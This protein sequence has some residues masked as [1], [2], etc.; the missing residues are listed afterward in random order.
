MLNERYIDQ[1]LSTENRVLR[2][3][4]ITQTYYDLSQEMTGLLGAENVN[5]CTFATHASKTAGYSI[6]H[7]IFP[8]NLETVLRRFERYEAAL[9]LLSGHLSRPS[10]GKTV[11]S[12]DFLSYIL[13]QVSEFVSQGNFL[14]F[15]DLAH[16]FVRFIW[17][18][19]DD[20]RP[21][22]AKFEQF[23]AGFR[24]GL[25]QHNGEDLL[26]DSFTAYY[27]AKFERDRKAKAEKILLANLLIGVYEQ[28][29]LQQAIEGALDAPVER[30]V[31]RKL[32]RLGNSCA[33]LKLADQVLFRHMVR[34][35]KRLF[36]EQATQALMVM[37]LPSGVKRLG[38]D[39][40]A[41]NSQ[42]FP[43]DLL[44]VRDPELVMVLQAWD[45]SWNSLRGSAARNW[46]S[47]AD[48][49]N[50]VVDYFRST[51]QNPMMYMAPFLP[52]QLDEIRR[53]VVPAGGL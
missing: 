46:A 37:R 20:K 30:L 52:K 43:A 17:A 48:R 28:T 9:G 14:V 5:W 2:N 31:A 40:T 19:Q 16:P 15:A 50:Y 26:I 44:E 1:T 41:G 6:R 3:L 47:L 10:A 18:F 51:Q 39:V 33:I 11:H 21:S 38:K 27:S 23:L 12:Y 35:L 45:R 22:L 36:E 49:M 7:E 13:I 4:K 34:V 53:G 29:R 32:G 8:T 25:L 42:P 24:P